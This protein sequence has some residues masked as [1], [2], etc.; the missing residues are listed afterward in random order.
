MRALGTEADVDVDTLTV[1]LR[2]ATSS[3]CSDGLSAMVRDDEIARVLG[4]TGGDH[5]AADAR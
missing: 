3:S 5:R 4:A 1:E 2:P